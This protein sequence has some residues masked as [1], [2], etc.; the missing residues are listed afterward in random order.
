[1]SVKYKVRVLET[2]EFDLWD[3]FI[4]RTPEGTIFHKFGWMKAAEKQSKTQFYPLICEKSG[5][6]I[7]SVFPVFLIKKLILNILF[8]PPPGCAIP[9]LGPIFDIQSTKQ[10]RIES[11]LNN[12][13]EAYNEYIKMKFNPDYY[14][15]LTGMEDVRPFKWLNY[16]IEPAYTYRLPLN[17]NADVIYNNLDN[18]IRNKINK[19]TTNGS[20]QIKKVKAINAKKLVEEIGSRYKELNRTFKLSDVYIRNLL[21]IYGNREMYLYECIL[22]GSYQTSFITIEYKNNMKFWLGSVQS[23]TTKNGVSEAIHWYNICE[24]LN[25]SYNY[26]ERIGANTKHLCEN[27]SKYGFRPQVYYKVEKWS[28]KGFIFY[29]IYENYIRKDRKSD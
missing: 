2:A 7:I 1:M 13:I 16:S 14:Y 17:D 5:E 28:R 3:E 27:K 15:I 8:S 4:D 9:E 24:A 29:Y 12:S 10:R 21:D 19:I 26:Y 20:M 23:K 11:D 25:R 22:N 18:R 6:G